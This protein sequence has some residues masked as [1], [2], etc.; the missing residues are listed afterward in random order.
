MHPAARRSGSSYGS[1]QKNSR[2]QQPSS[3]EAVALVLLPTLAQRGNAVFEAPPRPFRFRG[4][5]R[6]VSASPT[7]LK[8]KRRAFPGKALVLVPTLGVGMPSSRLR[9][10]LS[11]GAGR[12]GRR[13]S[14]TAFPRRAWERGV[15]PSRHSY[16]DSGFQRPEFQITNLICDSVYNVEFGNLNVM[17]FP[18]LVLH[19]GQ[20]KISHRRLPIRLRGTA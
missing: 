19:S 7:S 15:V 3:S 11:G 17:F 14:R 16:P 12:R 1:W 8:R 20:P 6:P 2:F 18:R 10:G 4:R 13:A 9:L 5:S